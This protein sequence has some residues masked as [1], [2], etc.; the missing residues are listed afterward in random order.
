[1]FMHLRRLACFLLGGWLMGSVLM[2]FVTSWNYDAADVVARSHSSDLAK[3]VGPL[4]GEQARMLF[5]HMANEATRSYGV[6]W[7]IMQMVIGLATAAALFLERRTRLY[8]I[9]VGLMLLL[10]LFECSVILPQLDYVGRSVDFVPWN[11]T[12][13]M[14]DQYWS[15][16]AVFLG[17]DTLKLLLGV[18]ITAA[19]LTLRNRSRERPPI[20]DDSE[21]TDPR[22][23][24]LRKTRTRVNS[25]SSREH[26]SRA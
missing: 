5:F 9:G 14:R 16:R 12:S 18:G 26:S 7:E 21:T 17:M 24:S 1:M 19:L 22:P 2:L 6:A 23:E 4:S 13:S 15:L 20:E 11:A 3:V 8:T 10:V 25:R